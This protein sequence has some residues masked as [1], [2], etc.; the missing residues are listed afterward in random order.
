MRILKKLLIGLV[1]LAVLLG[2]GGMFLPQ[3]VTVERAIVVSRP[4]S[5]VFPVINS[6]QRFNEWSPWFDLDPNA[7]YTYSG[8]TDGVGASMAW[9]GNA[10]A[11]SGKQTITQSTPNQSIHSDLEFTGQGNAKVAF[12]LTP[13]QTGTRVLWTFEMD[14]GANPYGRYFGLLMDRFIG[15]DYE[16]GLG[17]LKTLVEGFPNV[18]IEGAD[19]QIVEVTAKPILYVTASSTTDVAAI[20]QAYAQA[21]QM[22]GSAMAAGGATQ[23]GAPIGIDNYFDE[24]GYGFDAA[25]PVDRS[26]IPLQGPVQAGQTYAG[27]AVRVRHT[28]SYEGLAASQKQGEAFIAVHKLKAHDRV[29]TEFVSD[30]GDTEEAALISDIYLPVE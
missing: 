10:D 4:A 3:V 5:L 21:Y 16:K 20:G 17:R 28:G 29:Y 1:A 26:D 12:V 9:S 14:L 13:E 7:Q 24:R 11:G 23:T 25:I 18:D 22:I 6:Y 2:I 30:P 8:T 19:I 15:A 27:R